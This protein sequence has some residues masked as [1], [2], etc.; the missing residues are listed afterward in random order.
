MIANCSEGIYVNRL[1]NVEQLDPQ[2]GL[3]TGVT[4]DGCFL[5]KDG[6]IDRPVKNFRF[7][8][9]PM[10]FLNR[11]VAIGAP[12]R[13]ALGFMQRSPSEPDYVSQWPR[14]PMIVPPL[15]VDDFN[16]TMLSDAV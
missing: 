6:R 8:D 15:M 13:V 12:Q 4:R 10:Y 14:R 3:Q 5:I 7:V 16:F 11:L 9:S 2:S 1:S